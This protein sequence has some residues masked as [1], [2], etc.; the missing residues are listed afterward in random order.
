VVVLERR[1]IDARDGRTDHRGDTGACARTKCGSSAP[2]A[3]PAHAPT[4]ERAATNRVATS[5]G[6]KTSATTSTANTAP[7]AAPH[8]PQTAT[9]ARRDAAAAAPQRG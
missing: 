7:T 6:P 4:R 1:E 3:A 5:V 8:P 9:R 2:Q